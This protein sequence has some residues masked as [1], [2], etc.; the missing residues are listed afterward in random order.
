MPLKYVIFTDPAGLMSL[1][2]FD[3]I[4]SHSDV[5]REVQAESPGLLVVSAGKLFRGLGCVNGSVTLRLEH[6]ETRSI[7]DTAI[8]ERLYD[9]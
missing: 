3:S 6:N 5:V 2:A 1:R 4:T 9:L 7:A 8:V